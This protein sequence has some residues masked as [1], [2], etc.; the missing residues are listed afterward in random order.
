M[1]TQINM[2][3]S[4]AVLIVFM[5]LL[6]IG[7]VLYGVIHKSNIEKD[8]SQ[9]K[10]LKTTTIAETAFY[11]P[12]LECT[13]RGIKPPGACLEKLKIDTMTEIKNQDRLYNTK[14]YEMFGNS[15]IEIIQV[16]PRESPDYTRVIYDNTIP[17]KKT[18]SRTPIQLLDITKGPQYFA[19]GIMEVTTYET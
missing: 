1:K 17:G 7:L 19:F 4:I 15:K 11:L 9:Q 16:Y 3:E 13:F 2:F 18:I 10:G 6:G 5:F 8:I 14:Y 12:E